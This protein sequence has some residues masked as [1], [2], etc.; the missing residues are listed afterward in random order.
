VELGA[1]RLVGVDAAKIVSAVRE[2]LENE[3]EIRRRI[4][5]S[6]NPFGNGKASEKIVEILEETL[7][8]HSP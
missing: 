3:S 8:S 4:E 6:P 2:I 1:N 7:S 5:N